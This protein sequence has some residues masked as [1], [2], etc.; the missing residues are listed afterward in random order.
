MQTVVAGHGGFLLLESEVGQGTTFKIHLPADPL[1]RTAVTVPPFQADLPRGRDELVL[2]I[3]DEL[4]IRHITKQTLETFGYR[5]ITAS[6]GAEAIGLFA[7]QAQQIAV[8]ITDMMMPIMDGAAF[9]QVIRRI[10]PSIR[11]IAV[12]GIDSGDNVAK[13]THAGADHFLVKPYTADSL[14]KLVRNA[15]D[16][17]ART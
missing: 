17:P 8:V 13:A 7:S 11:V 9:I 10:K 1:L 4:S 5:V 2:V 15:L 14:L 12:S 3:D 16:Q 6:D